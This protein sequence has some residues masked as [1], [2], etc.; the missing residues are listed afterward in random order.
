MNKKEMLQANE[1]QALKAL[2]VIKGKWIKA[3][4]KF[5]A[6]ELAEKTDAEIVEKCDKVI[7]NIS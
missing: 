4:I 1:A 3:K 6:Y 2:I 5:L 7:N